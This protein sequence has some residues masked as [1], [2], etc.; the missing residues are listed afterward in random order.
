MTDLQESWT[1]DGASAGLLSRERTIAKPG[2]NRWLVPPAALAVHL[3]IGMAYGFSVFWLPLSRAIGVT[4]PV[5]CEGMGLATALF[6]TSCDWRVADLGWI[7]TLFFVLL[8]SSAAIWGGWLET[9]GPRKAGV[10]AACCWCGGMVLAGLGVMTHQ[11]WL[12]WIGSGF[13]GGIGLGLG[14]ISPVS[15]LIKWFPDRRGLATGMAIMGFGGGAMIGAPLADRLMNHFQTPT[16]IGVWQTFL[17]LAAV[18]FVFMLAGAFGYRV[19][20]NGWKPTGFQP[21]VSAKQAAMITHHH[22]HLRDAHKT[23]QFWLIWLVLC[24]NVSAGI[25]VIGMASP[26][27]QEIF[28]GRLLGLPELGFT[29]LDAGQKAA[30][31][32]IAAGF[33]GLL[34]LFNIGGRICWASASDKFGRKNTYF[35]FFI[36]GIALYILAP[37]VAHSGNQVLF[38]AMVCIIIS[39][40][41]GGFSTVP[42]YLADVF[43]TQFVGAIH[44][45]LLTAWATAGIVGPVVVNYLREA[46]IAAGVPRAQVYDYTMY[47]LAGF[48][49]LGL[50]CNALVR[51]LDEK[52][53]MKP[54]EVAALQ[55][56]GKGAAPVEEG[57]FGIGR[58]RFDLPALLAWAAV[59]IP[60]A[61]GVW[62]TARKT[63]ALFG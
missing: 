10:V 47:T 11:L 61:W 41:G 29:D 39:M 7:Y 35:I 16:D 9:A 20:P 55:A 42:A 14:Y 1:G 15:T 54:E 27:L 13:I 25:G 60:L 33:A 49:A 31:A 4:E 45:R 3:C 36:L 58:G 26:M 21:K 2:F 63:V 62:M 34:S 32:A 12:M 18:Y 19:P 5:V 43:G 6:T 56:G 17:T 59:G 50:L 48:L 40:Y 28:A 44:G 53:F 37:S 52:W 46:Q 57:S 38:V 22:V 8:G 24:L 51:P 23:R 30:I